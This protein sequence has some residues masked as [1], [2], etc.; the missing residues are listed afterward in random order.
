MKGR[1]IT[2]RA[3]V[4][5]AWKPALLA[6]L[7][8]FIEVSV[9]QPALAGLSDGLL[10]YFTFDTWEGPTVT[11]QS[12][13]GNN[14]RVVGTPA[15]VSQGMV[16]GAYH[17]TALYGTPCCSSFRDYIYL[18]S[19]PTSHLP[20]FSVSL[21]LK[22]DTAAN[23]KVTSAATWPPGSGWV[24]GFAYDE[25][26]T[27]NPA[28]YQLHGPARFPG[29]VAGVWYHDVMTYDGV[30]YREYVN[31]ELASEKVVDY[32]GALVGV[33][34][35]LEIGAWSQHGFGYDGLVDEF[36]VYNRALTQAE[37]RELASVSGLPP[38]CVIAGATNIC[39]GATTE[40]CGPDGM[41]GYSWSGP[42]TLPD[43]QC[44]TVGTAGNYG[45]TV[46]DS[47]GASN[48]CSITVTVLGG[49]GG[50]AYV[51]NFENDFS[52]TVNTESSIWSYRWK[53]SFTRD[54]NYALLPYFRT[55]LPWA[56]Q[57]PYYPIWTAS[58]GQV[59]PLIGVNDSGGPIYDPAIDPGANWP[60]PNGQST[61]H[62]LGSPDGSAFAVVS[63]LS[64]INGTVNIEL[65]IADLDGRGSGG[66]A[67]YVDKGS[68]AGNLATGAI[69]EG[70]DTG[71]FWIY[72]IPVSIG[73]RLNFIIGPN[74]NY[75]NDSTRMF[76]EITSGV[77]VTPPTIICSSDIVA[78]NDP[79][80]C[81]AVVNYEASA[82]DCSG[83]AS[84]TS[85]P[86]SGSVFPIGPTTVTV[87]AVDNAGNSNSCSFTVTVLDGNGSQAVM[88]NFEND[89]SKTVN[90]ESSIWS[91]RRK[92]SFT[93]DGVYALLPD[94]STNL[95]WAP[96]MP[97]FP[98]WHV[99]E[100]QFLPYIGVNDSGGQIYDPVTDPGAHW[101][102]PNGQSSIHPS[103]VSNNGHD[104]LAVVSWLSPFSGTVNIEMRITDLD[105]RTDGGGNGVAYYV[106]N[107]SAAGSLAS[108]SIPNGGDTGFF[109]IYN[110]PVSAGD[111]LNFIIGPDGNNIN[112]DSTRMFVEITSG[113]D[114][115]PPS[116][117]CPS[118][119]VATI[120][121][122]QCSA[123]VNYEASASDCSGIASLTSEPPSGSAFPK[124]TTTVT[125]TAV[126]NAGNSNSCNFTVTV[127]DGEAPR[128]ACRPAPNPSGKI[129]VPGKDGTSTNSP[130]GYY[131]LLAKDNCDPDP[132]IFVKDTGS[133]LVAGPF[134]DGDIVHVK[135]TG[136]EP[137]WSS[138]GTPPIVAVIS[139]NGNALVGAA[140]ASGNVT[141][142]A[143][144]CLVQP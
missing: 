121:P 80:Q 79:G 73:D 98:I 120:D 3:L 31:G 63:W 22:A 45:L 105:G 32:P 137:R 62:P 11:D 83:I 19:N 67:Y 49:N 93:R 96:Q 6:V 4:A 82:S 13:S 15:F 76:V 17:F 111:R 71:F 81:S 37:V 95:P 10:V 58:D 48:T 21:W 118:N 70:G 54:G 74:G 57:I 34:A 113:M 77:D 90:T 112:N 99:S 59:Y 86:P 119:I 25:A 68:A 69:P 122:G 130:S 66:V 144:G 142:D 1:I 136:G 14:G 64:P 140:D 44:V 35:R 101:P 27:D 78:T 8:G 12:A 28:G 141:P 103:A 47:H 29:F 131:Q 129:H 50:Q 143:N 51:S 91:Y 92:D 43:V 115:T 138:P 125:V 40:L 124:G 2:G 135:H 60:W 114:I 126:N 107:G 139:L 61:I 65:R 20:Q 38:E 117:T 110:V 42:E 46:I 33:G 18:D 16:G 106:D 132:D 52:K 55:N 85:D 75:Y 133:S 123:V 100:S 41:A 102:W 23:Y 36:R 26:W 88:Y 30:T 104:A 94:F 108:G 53:S 56:P 39:T 87:T 5:K 128:V 72:N 116:I 84:L 97:Y 127:L 109:W 7:L 134:K 89:F 24:L 9:S